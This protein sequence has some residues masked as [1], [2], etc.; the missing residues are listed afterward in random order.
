MTLTR[1][2]SHLGEPVRLGLGLVEHG[3]P[4]G[5]VRCRS[6]HH[7]DRQEQPDR[8]HEPEQLSAGDLLAGIVARGQRCHCRCRADT[9][10]IDAPTRRIAVATFGFGPERADGHTHVAMCHRATKSARRSCLTGRPI[11]CGSS[12]G[13]PGRRSTPTR[14]RPNRRQPCA[15]SHSLPN[16]RS[17]STEDVTTRHLPH[18]N[19]HHDQ[20]KLCVQPLTRNR[21]AWRRGGDG[22]GGPDGPPRS[23][24]ACV[25]GS[26]WLATRQR[27]TP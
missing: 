17:P 19:L 23:A 8:V 1:H 25:R 21:V 4:A 20:H 11:S 27:R 22:R 16:P 5:V 3:D 7:R 18:D 15:T 14:H 6:D 12:T 10:R 9:A 26:S 13:R 2:D 24:R